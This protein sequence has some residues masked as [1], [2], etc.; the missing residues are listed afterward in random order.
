MHSQ[1][2]VFRLV[3]YYSLNR[4]NNAALDRHNCRSFP[5]FVLV[6]AAAMDARSS[7]LERLWKSIVLPALGKLAEASRNI[8]QAGKDSIAPVILTRLLPQRR[9]AVFR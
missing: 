4:R 2:M 6:G 5:G 9:A 7:L 3:V 1:S 8:A